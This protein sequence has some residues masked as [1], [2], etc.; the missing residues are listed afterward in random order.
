MFQWMKI[1]GVD[2]GA[3]GRSGVLKVSGNEEV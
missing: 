1:Q 3:G 2:R